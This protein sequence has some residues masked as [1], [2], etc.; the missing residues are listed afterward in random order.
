MICTIRVLSFLFLCTN[1]LYGAVAVP[2]VPVCRTGIGV[3]AIPGQNGMGSEPTYVEALF[4]GYPVTVVS[5]AT[6]GSSD[7]GQ[8]RCLTCLREAFAQKAFETA[9]IH[10]TSQ[11]TATALNYLADEDAGHHIKA[12][13]L[14]SVLVS[15]NSAIYHTT[16][17]PLM[18][19]SF[20]S[21]LARLPLSYYW[22]PY[23]AKCLFPWYWPFGKQ[24]IKVLD[25]IP[26][27]LPIIIIH[28]KDDMQL[29]YDDACALYYGL[30]SR[31]NDNVYLISKDGSRHIHLI[32]E[33]EK[34]V[35][36]AILQR[37]GLL[38][39]RAV[40]E[41]TID[42]S[43]YQPDPLVFKPLY[44]SL[45]WKESCHRLVGY[46]TGAVTLSAL[47]YAGYYVYHKLTASTTS[48]SFS[49]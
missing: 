47:I 4:A 36:L 2:A 3:Y 44:D 11:G 45:V 19:T 39:S 15:G 28:S 34:N 7:L 30:R 32:D 49:T 37:H 26:T 21:S 22:A 13:I 6:P 18:G 42:L 41:P 35:V 12:L 43:A 27:T 16:H 46:G 48:P 40:G 17:G 38:T 23:C 10:A 29:S 8:G 5:V 31:G 33:R 9:I 14:E 1:F 20:L 24:P 25:K